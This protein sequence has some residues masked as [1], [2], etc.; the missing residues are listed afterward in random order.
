M[1]VLESLQFVPFGP[2]RFIGKSVY[3]R[4]GSNHSGFI[5]GSLWQYSK[6]VFDTL[7]RLNAYATAETDNARSARLSMKKSNS[8]SSGIPSVCK[9]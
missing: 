8:S 4:A 9:K 2:Y 3:A 7:D 6:P 5:F 1:A